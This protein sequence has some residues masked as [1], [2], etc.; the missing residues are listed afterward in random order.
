MADPY[1][2]LFHFLLSSR[3][4]ASSSTLSADS[5]HSDDVGEPIPESGLYGTRNDPFRGVCHGY[6]S[7]DTFVLVDGVLLGIILLSK[8]ERIYVI[9]RSAGTPCN[10][11][12]GVRARQNE[13]AEKQERQVHQIRRIGSQKHMIG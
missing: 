5:L 8:A 1:N 2:C 6:P 13:A 4:V 12:L 10:L 3:K 9:G 11:Y 7:V